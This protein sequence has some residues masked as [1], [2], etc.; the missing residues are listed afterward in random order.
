[1]IQQMMEHKKITKPKITIPMQ[2]QQ[3][4]L[5]SQ[6]QTLSINQSINQSIIHGSSQQQTL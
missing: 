4:Q 2:Q 6:S 1:M 3:Q 5:E